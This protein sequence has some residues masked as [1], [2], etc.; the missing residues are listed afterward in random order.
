M[1]VDVG[2]G[3]SADAYYRGQYD[4]AFQVSPI[5]L[6]NGIADAVQGS[7]MPITML[8]GGS[9]QTIDEAFATFLPM[10]GG[11]LISQSVGMYPFANQAVAANATIQQPLTLSMVMIAPVNQRGGYLTKLQTFSALQRSLALHN[12]AGGM[13]IVATPA[14]IYQN[15]LM[16]TMTDITPDDV[17]QKQIEWQLDFVQ[18][19]L[20][21][22]GAAAAQSSLMQKI[23]Q[24]GKILAPLSWSGN[25]SSSPANL[26]GNVGALGN[27]QNAVASFVGA[28]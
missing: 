16:L 15:M 2:S 7:L 25:L 10:P 12:S 28:L 17:K 11:T 1:S 18:P 4:L 5:I 9:P 19:I 6:Q 24:G 20:T 8:T 27:V 26:P 13:Y 21:V 23:T 14:Y 3:A 22:E